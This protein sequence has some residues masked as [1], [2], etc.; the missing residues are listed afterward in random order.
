MDLEYHISIQLVYDKSKRHFEARR[1]H[2]GCTEPRAR[3][4]DDNDRQRTTG[5]QRPFREKLDDAILFHLQ[6]LLAKVALR[7]ERP[8]QRADD[9]VLQPLDVYRDLLVKLA[10]P[11]REH[12]A[13]VLE[14]LDRA[15]A[16]CADI[17]YGTLEVEPLFA[18]EDDDHV[19]RIA[20]R[21][22]DVVGKDVL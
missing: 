20:S 11:R 5:S 21:L 1:F 2:S 15:L 16:K 8:V 3:G 14:A 19:V 4:N 10:A 9:P 7:V 6:P 17:V 12:R 13:V 22:L 18:H